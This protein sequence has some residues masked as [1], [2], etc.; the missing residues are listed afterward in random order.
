MQWIFSFVMRPTAHSS[1]YFSLCFLSVFLGIFGASFFGILL[2]CAIGFFRVFKGGLGWLYLALGLLC[3]FWLCFS[4][5]R[6]LSAF[7]RV[8]MGGGSP[9]N[10]SIHSLC[11]FVPA[12]YSLG[13]GFGLNLGLVG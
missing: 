3:L 11:V 9:K 12:A 10:A 7:E 5:P 4:C 1:A 2:L 8:Q 6:L 13:L